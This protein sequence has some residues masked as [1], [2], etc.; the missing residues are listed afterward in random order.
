MRKK[1]MKAGIILNTEPEKSV[2]TCLERHMGA[3]VIG[4]IGF[5]NGEFLVHLAKSA[6]ETLFFGFEVSKTCLLKCCNRA[7]TEGLQNVRLLHG[8]ARFLL[9]ECFPDSVF[10]GLYM[11]FPCPWPKKKHEKRRVTAGT[12]PDVLAAVLKIGA[13]FEMATDDETYAAEAEETLHGHPAIT[14]EG[15]WINPERAVMTKYERKWTAAEKTIHVIRFRKARSWTVERLHEGGG[16]MHLEYNGPVPDL[17]TLGQLQDEQGGG[18]DCRWVFKT[19]YQGS[20]GTFLL[21]TMTSDG[22]FRQHFFMKI[23]PRD[24]AVLVKLDPA[25]RPFVTPSVEGAMQ[26]LVFMLEKGAWQ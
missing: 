11:N 6:P 16:R 26:E 1:T 3:S 25:T 21:E 14:C 24:E 20:D 4:E 8:D 5:G 22:E 13:Y 2:K 19:S 15:H 12:F 18:K 9:R 23:V 17:D 7:E 10:D